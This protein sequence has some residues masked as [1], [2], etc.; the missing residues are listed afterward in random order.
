[1]TASLVNLDPCLA[2]IT[3]CYLNFLHS[4]FLG[5]N[6]SVEAPSDPAERVHPKKQTANQDKPTVGAEPDTFAD[7]AL[8]LSS[9][10]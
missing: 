7:V 8:H 3:F 10:R 1:M 4:A 5:Q 6:C 9:L 2:R